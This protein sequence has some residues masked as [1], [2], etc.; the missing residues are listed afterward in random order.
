MPLLAQQPPPAKPKEP[1]GVVEKALSWLGIKYRFGGTSS[2]RGFD[3]AGLVK[4]VFG[5]NGIALPRTAALQFRE[6]VAVAFEELKPGDLVFFRNTYKKGI[7]HVGI[8]LGEK[9]FIHAGSRQ[10]RVVVER[11]DLPYYLSRFA[12]GRRIARTQ[13]PAAVTA[14]A[15]AQE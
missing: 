10:H 12:G 11:I 13:P 4:K 3:C 15:S 5:S 1:D 7:S 8:Y 6:G 2:E 9:L 14:K